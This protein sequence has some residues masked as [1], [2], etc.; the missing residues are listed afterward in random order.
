M[1]IQRSAIDGYLEPLS[2]LEGESGRILAEFLAEAA[3]SGTV[4]DSG[5]PRRP[6]R[7][8]PEKDVVVV[9]RQPGTGLQEAGPRSGAERNDARARP[10]SKIRTTLLL[11]LAIYFMALGFYQGLRRE[12]SRAIHVNPTLSSVT[13]IT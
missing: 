7:R 2:E 3:P 11:A 6:F 5:G 10:R 12:T 13:V 9:G 4:P 1:N 8:V